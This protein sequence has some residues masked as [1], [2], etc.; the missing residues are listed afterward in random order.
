M[1]RT[2]ARFLPTLLTLV[3]VVLAGLT[4]AGVH[5]LVSLEPG[6]SAGALAELRAAASLPEE[7]ADRKSTRLNS[8]H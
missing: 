8:S 7:E 6:T 3:T 2:K 5:R 1:S 4:A